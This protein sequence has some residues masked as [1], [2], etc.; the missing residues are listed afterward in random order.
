MGPGTVSI[1]KLRSHALRTN[2]TFVL[3]GQL[4]RGFATARTHRV[5][6]SERQPRGQY[7]SSS[8]TSSD[9]ITRPNGLPARSIPGSFTRLLATLH[10]A[11]IPRTPPIA[12]SRQGT[13]T[14][15]DLG[16]RAGRRRQKWPQQH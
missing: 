13:H 4:D 9:Q 2:R 10:P 12:G 14:C 15:S 8:E 6:S 11:F 5:S 16:L 1:E 3:E 7:L